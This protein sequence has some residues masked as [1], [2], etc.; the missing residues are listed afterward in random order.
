M[1]GTRLEHGG[2]EGEGGEEVGLGGKG[3]RAEGR[4]EGRGG[5]EVDMRLMNINHQLIVEQCLFLLVK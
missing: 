1:A 5:E 4:G 3:K 2:K